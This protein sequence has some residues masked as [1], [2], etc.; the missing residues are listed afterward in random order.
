LSPDQVKA[1]VIRVSASSRNPPG[2]DVR[3][4]F[5]FMLR[6]PDLYPVGLVSG[7]LIY[8]YKSMLNGVIQESFSVDAFRSTDFSK[9]PVFARIKSDVALI[10]DFA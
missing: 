10:S 8:P 3:K 6:Q 9:I 2:V 7:L 4:S 1:Q 5:W